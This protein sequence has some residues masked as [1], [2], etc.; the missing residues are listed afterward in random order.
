MSIQDMFS[1]LDFFTVPQP[2]HFMPSILSGDAAK[3]DYILTKLANPSDQSDEKKGTTP[4]LSSGAGTS[5]DT[6]NMPPVRGADTSS[7]SHSLPPPAKRVRIAELVPKSTIFFK[8]SSSH[9][10]P[11]TIA[12][13]PELKL[14]S[15]SKQDAGKIDFDVELS[16]LSE[17]CTSGGGGAGDE[18]GVEEKA[19][20]NPEILKEVTVDNSNVLHVCGQLDAIS[21]TKTKGK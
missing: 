21:D 2:Q 4:S 13:V 5:H 8:E 19:W 11:P 3:V 6:S 17:T 10:T 20:L 14:M 1:N 18:V 16:V 15:L 9:S 12:E 7:P